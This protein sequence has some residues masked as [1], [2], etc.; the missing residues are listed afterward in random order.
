MQSVLVVQ[1]KLFMQSSLRM[2]SAKATGNRQKGKLHKK[3][4]KQAGAELCQAQGKLKFICFGTLHL[5][6][7]V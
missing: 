4:T 6:V 1:G 2:K 7:L 5:I 3:I